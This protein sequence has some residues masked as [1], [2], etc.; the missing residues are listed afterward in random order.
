MR[1]QGTSLPKKVTPLGPLIACLSEGFASAACVGVH[2]K[3]VRNNSHTRSGG[4]YSPRVEEPDGDEADE[5]AFGAERT[6][7]HRAYNESSGS[8]SFH[9]WQLA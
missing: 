6:A 3:F 9:S 2:W 7:T 1:R 5:L 8:Y 4:Q